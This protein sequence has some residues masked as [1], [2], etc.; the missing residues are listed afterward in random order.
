MFAKKNNLAE[1][2]FTSIASRDL[3]SMRFTEIH[4]SMALLDN[5]NNCSVPHGL[6]L[7]TRK[8]AL[9][10]AMRSLNSCRTF[11]YLR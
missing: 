11:A 4:L 3:G 9:C 5:P 2:S 7:T 8:I 1:T 10:A 6:W